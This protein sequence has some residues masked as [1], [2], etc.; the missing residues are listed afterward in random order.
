MSAIKNHSLSDLDFVTN[1]IL[2]HYDIEVK[3]VE[4][5]KIKNSDKERAIYRVSTPHL[6]YCL[7][8]VYY[9]THDLEFVVYLMQYLKTKGLHVPEII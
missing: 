5:I 4:I 8:K 7:K 9:S 1:N 6:D 2:S 3:K